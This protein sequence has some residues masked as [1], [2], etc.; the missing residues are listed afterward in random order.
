MVDTLGAVET[1]VAGT[2]VDRLF[3]SRPRVSGTALA[4]DT[5]STYSTAFAAIATWLHLALVLSV[6]AVDPEKPGRTNADE[7][8]HIIDTTATILAGL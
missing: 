6:F 2:L 7:C 1:R 5:P 3:T 8:I 4:D